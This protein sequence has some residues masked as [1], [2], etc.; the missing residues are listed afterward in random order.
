MISI[1]YFYSTRTHILVFPP[2]VTK[3]YTGKAGRKNK[4]QRALKDLQTR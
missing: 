2:K 4:A 1:V 3:N